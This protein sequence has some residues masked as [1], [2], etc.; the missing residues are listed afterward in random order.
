ME[1]RTKQV[2]CGGV[3]IGGGAPVTVQSMTNT[4]TRDV[5]ATVEQIAKLADAG[6]EI[7]RVAVPDQEA[8]AAIGQIKKMSRLPIVADIHFDYRLALAAIEN[9]A[10]KIRINPGNIGDDE[11]V[12]AVLAAAR[13]RGIPIRA[14]VNAGSLEKELLRKYGGVT[15]AALAE[16][17][18]SMVRRMREM[19]F[20][21]IVVSLKSSD[22]Q[23]NYE[24]HLLAARE[25]DLPFHIGLTE[26][27]SAERGKLKSA[28][29]I[30]A[31]LLAG[32]GDTLRVSLTGD[33]IEEVLFA[34]E[35]LRAAGIRKSGIDLISC[36]TCGR[37]GVDLVS[38]V[39]DVQE[40]LRPL[41]EKRIREGKEPLTVA[42]MG[43]EVNGPGEA[44]EADFGVACGRGKGLL[45][46]K[47][48]PL[49]TCEAHEIADALYQMIEQA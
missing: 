22:V 3:P 10:D 8:A 13:E 16:S 33:P 28:V 44:K 45:F 30:G 26:S 40:R 48:E 35:L 47:G 36:P 21:D 6:C 46:C 43:C 37:T 1:R 9:G 38:I 4:D 41:E 34:K 39:R 29:G 27:G 5:R 20:E 15:A 7:I 32:I 12:G 17:A 18:V 23:L 49:R 19:K 25:L 14:G 11:R 24:A 2:L 42:V 31:L